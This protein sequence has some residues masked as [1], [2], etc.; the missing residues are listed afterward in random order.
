MT[1]FIKVSP[2]ALSPEFYQKFVLD[3][4]NS[5]HQVPGRTGHSVDTTKSSATIFISVNM[6]SFNRYYKQY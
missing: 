5:P 4:Y 3:F 1:G 2:N 6:Q